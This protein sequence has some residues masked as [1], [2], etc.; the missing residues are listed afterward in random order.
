MPKGASRSLVDPY[1]PKRSF[2]ARAFLVLV[3][4]G[5]VGYGLQAA[6]IVDWPQ[7]ARWVW[8]GIFGGSG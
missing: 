6:R 4:L 1:R 2:W 5:L 7:V 3:I 8:Y